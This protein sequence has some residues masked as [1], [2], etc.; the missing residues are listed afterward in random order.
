MHRFFQIS[1]GVTTM[2]KQ[3]SRQRG[4]PLAAHFPTKLLT[5]SLPTTHSKKQMKGR[6]SVRIECALLF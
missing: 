5:S 1:A 3:M 2:H 6:C 4:I